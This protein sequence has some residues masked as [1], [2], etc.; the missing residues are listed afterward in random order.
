[1]TVSN[2]QKIEDLEKTHLNRQRL[3]SDL[4]GQLWYLLHQ[5]FGFRDFGMLVT[6]LD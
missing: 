6:V 5:P 4:L 2:G 3:A 1:M